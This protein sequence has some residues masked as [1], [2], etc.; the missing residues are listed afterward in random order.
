[1]SEHTFTTLLHV[2]LGG[3]LLPDPLAALL[4]EGWVDASVN[5]PSAFQLTFTD[6][7]GTLTRLYPQLTVGSKAVI[8]PFTDGIRGNPLITGEVTALEVDT[9]PGGGRRLVL[10]GY[11]PGHRLLRNRRV[12]GYPQMTAS[13]IVRKLAAQCG[14]VLGRV[15]ATP[16]VYELATQPGITDWDYLSRLAAENDVRLSFDPDGKLDF[17]RLAPAAGAPA[18]TTPALQSP[19]VLEFGRNTLQSRIALTSADQVGRVTVRGWD[20]TAKRPLAASAVSGTTPDIMADVTSAQLTAAFGQAE[21]DATRV[22]YTTPSE[23]T[24]A[25]RSLADDVA[26]SFGELEV[27]VTGN[28]GLM[29]GRPV[30]VKGA[31]FPF[32]GKYTATGVRHVFASGQPYV[33]WLTV[34]GR[35]FRSLYGLAS[36]GAGGGEPAAPLPGVAIALVTNVKDPLRLGRVRL[37]FPWL[38]DT[39]ESGWCRVAQFGGVGGGG[40]LLPNVN[41]EVLCAFDRG[42]LEHPYVLAGL[43]NGVDKATREPDG[44]AAVDPVSGQVNWRSVTARSGHTVEL[45]ERTGAA[46]ASSGIRLRTGDGALTVQLDEA[47]TT[48][49]LTSDGTVTIHG[50]RGVEVDS[51]GDLTLSATGALNLSAGRG[52]HLKAG[53]GMDVKTRLG[54]DVQTPGRVAVQAIGNV[55]ITAATVSLIGVTTRNGVPF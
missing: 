9:E 42:S 13:D 10:R 26:G 55:G 14:L 43:Y 40:L 21:L 34:S 7:D 24:H 36:G 23:V 19:Y 31:G 8:S 1:M 51:G 20:M 39:Y 33:T 27:A 44:I 16:T 6:G 12:A 5:V 47:K 35:Q 49:T 29:P 30:A 2:Q 22:P 41:D 46:R 38:S 15:E 17:A 54:V 52:L 3:S 18:D 28:P 11:D 50:A 32:E 37:R 25:A 53:L 48:L 4:T 45:L